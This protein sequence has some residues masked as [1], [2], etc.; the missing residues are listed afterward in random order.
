M[1]D[2]ACDCDS[3]DQSDELVDSLD[4]SDNQMCAHLH[5]SLAVRLHGLSQVHPQ[6]AGTGSAPWQRPFPFN[7][8][9]ASP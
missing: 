7:L 6:S 1:T 4:Q 5:S 2:I 3:R 8:P 9:V